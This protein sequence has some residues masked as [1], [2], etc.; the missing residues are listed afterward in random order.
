MSHI[1]TQ[2]GGMRQMTWLHFTSKWVHHVLSNL[3]DRFHV[4]SAWVNPYHCWPLIFDTDSSRWHCFICCIDWECTHQRIKP[5]HGE[6]NSVYLHITIDIQS[7][8]SENLY[9][10]CSKLKS[11]KWSR[12]KERANRAILLI[13]WHPAFCSIVKSEKQFFSGL[14]H[15]QL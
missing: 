9:A 2:D 7:R 4:Y 15:V 1:K 5:C 8:K 12:C 14:Y 13:N 10:D 3:T 6:V 11:N